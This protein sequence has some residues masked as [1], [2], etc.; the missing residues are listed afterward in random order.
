[1]IAPEM[2]SETVTFSTSAID[3][4]PVQEAFSLFTRRSPKT[5]RPRIQVKPPA[6]DHC[7]GLSDIEATPCFLRP[8]RELACGYATR[9]RQHAH[10]V[11]SWAELANSVNPPPTLHARGG[12]G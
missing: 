2:P 4:V 11:N 8:F 6:R 12:Y 5:G 7:Q 9:P 3:I 1:M 10:V